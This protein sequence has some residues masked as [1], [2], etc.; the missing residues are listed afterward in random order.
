[1][2]LEIRHDPEQGKFFAEV[3]G[4]ECVLRYRRLDDRTLEYGST[5]VPPQQRG[6]GI[7]GEIV[8]HALR[9]ARDEGLEVVPSCPF[10]AAWIERTGRFHDLIR[11]PAGSG[12]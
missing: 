6:R 10:V 1:M 5:F 9:H 2:D 4:Q 3:E 7:A 11:K 12:G 8:E